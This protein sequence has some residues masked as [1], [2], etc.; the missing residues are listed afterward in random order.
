MALVRWRSRRSS[1]TLQD[2]RDPCGSATAVAACDQP[3]IFHVLDAE[4]LPDAVEDR[5][6]ACRQLVARACVRARR[7]TLP[8]VR[9]W[10]F[11]RALMST[12]AVTLGILG[13]LE[14]SSGHSG[15]TTG[16]SSSRAPSAL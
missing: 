4:M 15:V 9:A 5:G 12:L 16:Y 3:Q 2:A 11:S 10:S 1:A 8:C 7:R 14:Y 6:C 13:V